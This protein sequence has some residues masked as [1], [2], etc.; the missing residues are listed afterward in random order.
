MAFPGA[1]AATWGPS[2]RLVAAGLGVEV[3]EVRE[4]YDRVPTD[5]TLEVACGVIE[6]GT[7]GAVRTQTVG[8]VDG[9]EC[10]VI[11]HV[12]RMAADLAPGVADGRAGDGTTRCTSRVTPTSTWR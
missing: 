2:I 6:A 7:C 12:N 9:R 1:Q 8:V 4:Y 5:R 10:I 11:E 3:E